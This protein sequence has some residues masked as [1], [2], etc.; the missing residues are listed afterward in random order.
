MTFGLCDDKWQMKTTTRRELEGR[1]PK[2]KIESK[3]NSNMYYWRAK[4]G[5]RRRL[6]R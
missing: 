5:G 3:Y 4:R 6:Q 1:Y 2:K